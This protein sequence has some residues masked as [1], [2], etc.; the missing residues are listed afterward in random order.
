MKHV[1]HYQEMIL[2]RLGEI[3]VVVD[4]TV[5]NG[6]DTLAL[7]HRFPKARIYGFDIQSDALARTRERLD[8]AGIDNVILIEDSHDRLQE[9]IQDPIDVIVFNLGYLPGSDHA[10]HTTPK[11][12]LKALSAGLER[13]GEGG[14]IL[15]TSYPGSIRGRIEDLALTAFL[16]SLD[17]KQWDATTI[18]MVNQANHPPRLHVIH[19]KCIR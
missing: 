11:S 19:K 18:H 6:H 13:L 10:I 8:E 17:Q 15:I 5:G 4:A 7:A 1:S 16:E 9:H 14:V 12:T 3:T 2:S